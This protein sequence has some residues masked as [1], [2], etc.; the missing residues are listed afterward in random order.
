MP[1]ARAIIN[2]STGHV[3]TSIKEAADYLK[4][5]HSS[6]VNKLKGRRKND[7]GFAYI[8]DLNEFK[9][10]KTLRELELDL[11][12]EAL[13]FYGNNKTITAKKL[14]IGIATL[15]RKLKL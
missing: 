15:H 4:I 8:E 7:T 1:T 9:N 2:R 5:T 6:L 10:G 12:K 14:G 3:F 11:I 13:I